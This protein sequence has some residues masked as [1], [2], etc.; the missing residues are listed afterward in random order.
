VLLETL[1]EVRRLIEEE[2]YQ[3]DGEDS[4]RSNGGKEIDQKQKQ[5]IPELR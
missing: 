4:G 2:W 3:E 5:W 1:L